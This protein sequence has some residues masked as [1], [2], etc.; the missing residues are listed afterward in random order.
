MS[1]D[2]VRYL[3]LLACVVMLAGFAMALVSADWMALPLL[4]TLAA[5]GTLLA[6]HAAAP[7]LCLA[8]GVTASVSSGLHVV[9]RPH[10]PMIIASG[11]AFAAGLAA[12]AAGLV[13]VR[14]A[15]ARGVDPAP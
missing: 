5:T 11:L 12:V 8:A 15:D 14:Q 1:K 2:W 9:F 4:L 7:R 10:V 6:R 13:L 3:A